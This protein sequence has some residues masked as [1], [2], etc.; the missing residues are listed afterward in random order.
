M[1]NDAIRIKSEEVDV[2]RMPNTR[3]LIETTQSDA[4]RIEATR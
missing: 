3:Q 1:Y 4:K 2:Q